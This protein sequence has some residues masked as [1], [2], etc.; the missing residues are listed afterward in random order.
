MTVEFGPTLPREMQYNQSTEA[1]ADIIERARI[2][3]NRRA[4]PPG[5]VLVPEEPT[6]EMVDA[7]ERINWKDSDVRGN[8]I[9]Q[10]QAMIAAAA[11]EK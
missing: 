2:R 11:K 10:W 7:A 1:P 4:I 6:E 9:N 3:W 8:F 5:Y